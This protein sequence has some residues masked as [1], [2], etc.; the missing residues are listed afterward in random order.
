MLL[1]VAQDKGLRSREQLLTQPQTLTD[2]EGA[3]CIARAAGGQTDINDRYMRARQ[4]R[5]SELHREV[6]DATLSCPVS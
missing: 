3:R 6:C 5:D 1:D 4:T 2:T